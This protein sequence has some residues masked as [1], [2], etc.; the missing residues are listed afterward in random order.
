MKTAAFHTLGC[1]VNQ[2]ETEQIKEELMRSGYEVVDFDRPADLYVINTCTVTHVSD[3]KSRSM[4][5]RALKNNPEATIVVTGCMAEL[6]AEN[7]ARMKGVNWVIGNR[8]KHRIAQIIDPKA[9]DHPDSHILREPIS[10]LDPI[11]PVLYH[12]QHERTRA[13][14]KVQD[15]CQSFCTYCIVPYTRGPVR[16]K[17][18]DDVIREISQLVDIGYREIVLTG[19]HTGQYGRSMEGWNLDRLLTE[20]FTQVQGS[21]RIR[22]SSIEL[23]EVT[24]RLIRSF[25][26]EP[27]LC[28]HLHLPLQ[29]GSDSILKRMGRRYTRSEFYDRV[30]ELIQLVPDLGLAADVMVGFPGE[31]DQDFTATRELLERL[32]LLDLHV[33]KYSPRPGTPAASYP[34]QIDE[35]V[36]TRRSNE[37]LALARRQHRSFLEKRIGHRLTVLAEKCTQNLCTGLSDNYINIEFLSPHNLCGEFVEVILEEINEDR[38]VASITTVDLKP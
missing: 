32:P 30:M 6:D 17:A 29:S 27:R 7:V 5:R 38:A 21:Y 37:L 8:D 16:S 33:F 15:G 19:I 3:R 34:D 36:K 10:V 12:D 2:V 23:G 25:A 35:K 13:F 24:D 14:V 31:T 9:S 26:E 20:I 4:I 11:Q 18:P 28:K 1:K 22:L